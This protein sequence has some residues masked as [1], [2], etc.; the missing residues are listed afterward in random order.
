[1]GH[2]ERLAR[3]LYRS[4]LRAAHDLDDVAG[5]PA[6]R[7][8]ML[9]MPKRVWS[10]DLQTSIGLKPDPTSYHGILSEFNK[11]ELFRPQGQSVVEHVKKVWRNRGGTTAIAFEA[12]KG[13]KEVIE[14]AKKL[15]PHKIRH[16]KNYEL[17]IAKRFRPQAKQLLVGHPFSF[18]LD[19]LL[20]RGVLL[21]DPQPLQEG[22]ETILRSMILNKPSG[23][24]LRD[25]VHSNYGQI[26][27]PL[28]RYQVWIGGEAEY[29]FTVI[30][31][32]SDVPGCRQILP[33]I[34]LTDL[35]EQLAANDTS[36]LD[37][38]KQKLKAEKGAGAKQGVRVLLGACMWK[39]SQLEASLTSNAWLP[40]EQADLRRRGSGEETFRSVCMGPGN[41]PQKP[42]K[43]ALH[44]AG[45][46][47]SILST[48]PSLS[49]EFGDAFR[50]LCELHHQRIQEQFDKVVL[51][52]KKQQEEA[53]TRASAKPGRRQRKLAA[54]TTNA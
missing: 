2:K 6:K 30:H 28:L 40:I 34:Y 43:R 9:G 7:A 48:I 26:F 16:R 12:L 23:K 5:S 11:G 18:L 35:H 53:T 50:P 10:E 27:G 13:M 32:W 8:L 39:E 47:A 42:W 52:L 37:A 31:Q 14:S 20:H 24:L 29:G 25:C 54:N 15:P 4:T 49:S 1:M 51:K 44:E 22:G 45:H 17:R 21:V 38:I 41:D 3:S 19:A 46:N 33:N 36:G